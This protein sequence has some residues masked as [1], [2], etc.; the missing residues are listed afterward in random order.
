MMG[1][2]ELCDHDPV[3]LLLL[4]AASEIFNIVVRT[5]KSVL[6]SSD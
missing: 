5:C 6:S 3:T 1:L 2:W 4:T